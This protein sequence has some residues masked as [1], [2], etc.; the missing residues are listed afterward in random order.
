MDIPIRFGCL[1][2]LVAVLWIV[3]R[4]RHPSRSQQRDGLGHEGGALRR[5]R[6][7]QAPRSSCMAIVQLLSLKGSGRY[8]NRTSDPYRVKV[9][10]YL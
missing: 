5:P 3:V 9:V 2:L 6:S 8:W 1:D 7:D 4:D 10:L